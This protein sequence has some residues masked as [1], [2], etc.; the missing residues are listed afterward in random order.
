MLSRQEILQEIRNGN[1][2]F[3]GPEE[4]ISTNSIDVSLSDIMFASDADYISPLANQKF[5]VADGHDSESVFYQIFARKILKAINNDNKYFTLY[6]GMFYLAVTNEVIGTTPNSGIVPMMKAKSTAGRWGLTTSL[7]A[8]VGDVGFV[9]RWTLE[10]R[11][12]LNILVPVGALIGQVTFHRTSSSA[13]DAYSGV[14][15][16]KDKLKV[17]PKPLHVRNITD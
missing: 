13:D 2:I 5:V 11:P 4:Q 8:G 6:S 12:A 15:N 14:Y 1:I 10:V 7:C 3:D 17:L 9:N 16:A